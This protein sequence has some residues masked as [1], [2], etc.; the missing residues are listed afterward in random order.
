MSSL[1]QL[2]AEIH[3]DIYRLGVFK[4][5][6][7]IFIFFFFSKLS[8]KKESSWP[9][10]MGWNHFSKLYLSYFS[11][12][13]GSQTISYTIIFITASNIQWGTFSQTMPVPIWTLSSLVL[14]QRAVNNAKTNKSNILYT[15]RKKILWR[16]KVA[17][18]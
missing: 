15:I 18:N 17:K 16:I 2:E 5:I 6:I 13:I 10:Y 3:R 14:K 8:K 12:K 1:A 9:T 4:K 11:F 7:N